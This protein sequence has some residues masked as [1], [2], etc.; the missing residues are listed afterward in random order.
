MQFSDL[1][2]SPSVSIKE[3]LEILDSTAKQILFVVDSDGLLLGTVTDGD[4]R[5]GICLLYTSPSQRD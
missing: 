3:T 5:R 4:V 2:I 1:L